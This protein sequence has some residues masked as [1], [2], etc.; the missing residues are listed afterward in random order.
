MY[1]GCYNG[2]FLWYWYLRLWV[3]PALVLVIFTYLLHWANRIPALAL[4][5]L[6][7]LL[8]WANAIPALAWPYTY[9][10]TCRATWILAQVWSPFRIDSPRYLVLVRWSM[11]F[12]FHMSGLCSHAEN[13]CSAI[14]EADI[15]YWLYHHFGGKI[16][17][18]YFRFWPNWY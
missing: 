11:Y 17:W 16:C 9:I 2:E 18:R 13:H 14:F 6:T 5:L 7:Y 8:H 4:V 10:C 12:T 1:N 3:I 15:T